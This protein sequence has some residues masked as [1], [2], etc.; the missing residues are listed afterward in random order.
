MSA[1]IPTPTPAEQATAATNLDHAQRHLAEA[2]RWLDRTDGGTMMDPVRDHTGLALA[3]LAC[4][5]LDLLRGWPF[6][7]AT[8]PTADTAMESANTGAPHRDIA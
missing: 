5:L 8:A 4:E 6:P 2:R 3:H 7:T 1:H